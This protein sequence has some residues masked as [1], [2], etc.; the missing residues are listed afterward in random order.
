M[1]SDSVTAAS[2]SATF[3]KS[4]AEYNDIIVQIYDA[5]FSSPAWEQALAELKDRLDASYLGLILRPP[6]AGT[7]GLMAHGG[8]RFDSAGEKS[9]NTYYHLLEPFVGLQMDHAV[10]VQDL[11]ELDSWEKHPF[12]QEFLRPLNN[13]HVLAADMVTSGGVQ[14][15]LR[16][17]RRHAQANFGPQDLELVNLLIP[18]IKRAVQIQFEIGTIESVRRFYSTALGN[19]MVGIILLDGNGRVLDLNSIAEDLLKIHAPLTIL[20]GRLSSTNPR[21]DVELQASIQRALAFSAA[22]SPSLAHTEALALSLQ[23]EGGLSYDDEAAEGSLGLLIR[24]IAL[25]ERLEGERQPTVAIFL[26]DPEYTHPT[27]ID[28][29]RRLFNF[30]SAEANL[31]LKLANGLK[32]EEAASDLGISPNTARAQLRSIF[33]KTKVTRQTALVRLIINSVASL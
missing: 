26:R 13:Y 15:R 29:V 25:S 4:F 24:S 8:H 21:L 9:Y 23:E 5:P 27:S 28:T 30:T 11:V 10:T 18:H 17:C 14:C 6:S 1:V 7:D 33:A 3:P 22:P 16:A 20:D 31:A 12:Y 2:D 32:V 19:M